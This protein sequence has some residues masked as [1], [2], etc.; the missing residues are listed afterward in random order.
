MSQKSTIENNILNLN[1]EAIYGID[2]ISSSDNI[3]DNNTVVGDGNQVY[4]ILISNG[5]NNEIN[6][7]RIKANGNGKNLT[8]KNLDS[9]GVGNAGIYLKDNSTN[10]NLANNNITSTKGY[11][12]LVDDVAISNVIADNYLESENGIGDGA[13]SN[14]EG[15]NVSEN[16]VYE[17]K[18]LS[19]TAQDVSY[20]GTGTFTITLDKSMDGA[21]VKFYDVD[22]KLF[23][24]STVS[25]G[26]VSAEYKFDKSYTPGQY[27]FKAIVSKVGYK[28]IT[29]DLKFKITNGNIIITVGNV[30][31]E[32]GDDVN[33]VATVLDEFG[34]PI[35]NVLVNFERINSAGRATT[36]GN[37]VTDANGI[38]T[39]KYDTLLDVGS[40]KIVSTVSSIDNYNDANVSSILNVFEKISITGNK[41]YSVYYGNTVTYKIRI[42]DVNTK[43]AISGK[44]VT[45]KVNGKT[46]TVSTDKNGYASYK[47]KLAAGSYT[48]TA[49]YGL[50]KVSNKITFKPTV[51]AKNLSKKKAKTIKYTVKVLNNKG[52]ILKNKKVTFKVKNKKYTAKTNK[53]GIA[54][55]TLKNLKVG[56]YAVSSTY[57]GCTVKTTLTIK[58]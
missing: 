25:N 7:N 47:V 5:K 58:K 13:V 12:I 46:K 28:T 55:L 3:I 20:L 33:L 45:F 30:S 17:A 54:T 22:E 35:S 56:K 32:Q 37:S 40:H 48:I 50:K 15:N 27:V 19:V 43:E 52:K 34:N 23:S 38:A 14:A 49:T 29:S 39:F 44:A 31:M 18:I 26:I 1:S 16:F 11:S 2:M 36:L 9:L 6:K 21:T 53:K 10:N 8:F 42:M 51:I 4:G 41:A 24:Q 57:G